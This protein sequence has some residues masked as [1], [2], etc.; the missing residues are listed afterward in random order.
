MDEYLED[1]L[2]DMEG[3]PVVAGTSDWLR[4]CRDDVSE[5]GAAPKDDRSPDKR[6]ES[7]RDVEGSGLALPGRLM[8]VF[9]RSARYAAGGRLY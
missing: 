1:M 4:W 6:A 5:G 8:R 7:R 3:R 2:A 9:L